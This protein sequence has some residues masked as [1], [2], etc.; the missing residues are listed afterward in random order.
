MCTLDACGTWVHKEAKLRQSALSRG[1]TIG[2][3]IRTLFL[4]GLETDW[5][6]DITDLSVDTLLL[7]EPMIVTEPTEGQF[8]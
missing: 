3:F 6:K 1:E 2:S 5:F 4:T 8:H 7:Y